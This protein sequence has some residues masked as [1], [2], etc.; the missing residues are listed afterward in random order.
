M[1]KTLITYDKPVYLGTCILDLSKLLMYEFHYDVMKAKYEE[2]VKLLFTDTDSLCYEIETEDVYEDFK[3]M[4]DRFDF[5][6]YSQNHKCFDVTNKKVIGKFKDEANGKPITE[7][8]GLRPKSYSYQV[9]CDMAQHKRSKGV[10]KN[11]INQHLTHQNYFKALFGKTKE[12]II[13]NVN[14]NIINS[15]NHIL[16]SVSINKIGLSALDNKRYVCNNNIH[17]L[18]LGHYK[19]NKRNL[20]EEHI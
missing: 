14:F 19:I 20:K 8:I 1:V 10:K 17:T 7:F 16:N 9:D 4:K 15:T 11:A 13:Q 12:E 18:A 5:S 6:E 2:K 3:E